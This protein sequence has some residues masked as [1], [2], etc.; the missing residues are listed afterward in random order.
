ME[1]VF[2]QSSRRHRVGRTRIRDVLAAPVVVVE[3]ARVVEQ[4]PRVLLL[5]P[6]RSGRVLEVVVV[7]EPDRVIVIHA[8][9]IRTRFY[10][11]YEE[12]LR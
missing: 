12:G 4:A 3:I 2:T 7:M 8:M 6:D 5:G 11:L 1:I 10:G 9:D